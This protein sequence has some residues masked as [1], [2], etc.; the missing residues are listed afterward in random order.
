MICKQCGIE[1]KATAAGAKHLCGVTMRQ[2]GNWVE[3][4]SPNDIRDKQIEDATL[5]ILIKW[6]LSHFGLKCHP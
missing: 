4:L 2:A 6:K 1:S 3:G 5:S